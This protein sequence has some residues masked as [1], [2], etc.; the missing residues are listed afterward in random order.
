MFDLSNKKCPCGATQSSFVAQSLTVI[1]YFAIISLMRNSRSLQIFI[2]VIFIVCVVAGFFVGVYFG[3]ENRPAVQ[4]V[5]VLLNKETDKPAGVDFSP[6]WKAWSII[7]EKYVIDHSTS[8][9]KLT[10]QDRV[11]GA[12]SGLADSLGDPYTVF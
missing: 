10:D 6:F 1:G 4:K 12:I 3:Y 5:T 11:W 7:N 2:V 9:P 8:S